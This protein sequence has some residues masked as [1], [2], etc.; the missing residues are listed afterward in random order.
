MPADALFLN[1]ATDINASGLVCEAVVEQMAYRDIDLDGLRTSSR[2]RSSI[3]AETT[4]IYGKTGDG[5]IPRRP[6][7]H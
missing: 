2:R 1:W 4:M 7:H 6:A 5:E 3:T